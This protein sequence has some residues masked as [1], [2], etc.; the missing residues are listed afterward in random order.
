MKLADTPLAAIAPGNRVVSHTGMAGRIGA[1]F[2]AG[3]ETPVASDETVD[4]IL[5]LWASGKWTLAPHAETGRIVHDLDPVDASA[6]S[7]RLA[8]LASDLKAILADM[9]PRTH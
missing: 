1:V 3:V 4:R 6:A 2:P 5:V 7:P 9:P 8:K